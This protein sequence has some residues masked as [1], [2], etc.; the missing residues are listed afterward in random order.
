MKFGINTL[1]WGATFGPDDFHRLPAIKAA[2]FDGIEV[3]ILDPLNF[4]AEAIHKELISAGLECTAVAIIPRGLGLGEADATARS[5]AQA[6]VTAC[7]RQAAEAGANV[8]A[9]PLYS[10]VG[11]LTG[12]RRTQD[13]WDRAVESWQA[14]AG[15][16]ANV[17]VDIGIE[18]LNRFETYFLNTAADGAA[19]C[20]AVGHPRV[21]LL[22]DTFH[23]NIEEKSIGDAL[24]SASRHLK[25]LHTCENDRGI[26]G[27]GHVAWNELFS[28]VAEI[29]YDRWLTIESFG[30]ALGEL[31]AAAAIWRDLAAT[32][33]DIATEGVKFLRTQCRVPHVRPDQRS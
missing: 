22:F 9:G 16:A 23:A 11:Y 27:S 29:G 14:L 17:G 30:F 4:P 2:G 25:H 32:P 28:T 7:I 31:S 21:G 19:F 13:E 1:L 20:D 33:D 3:A 24:R 18:P 26:P 6:H 10:P 8:L 15:T 12:S 5:K